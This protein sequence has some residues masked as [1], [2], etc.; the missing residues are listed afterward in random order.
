MRNN[1]GKNIHIKR[2]ENGIKNVHFTDKSDGIF[3]FELSANSSR[4]IV[5]CTHT[6]KM[7]KTRK[8]HWN[9]QCAFS[10]FHFFACC[11]P[12]NEQIHKSLLI[13]RQANRFFFVLT[14]WKEKLIIATI[15]NA[16]HW[17]TE[18]ESEKREEN[19]WRIL[20]YE[21][22]HK[23]LYIY[24]LFVLIKNSRP[25]E[26]TRIWRAKEMDWNARYGP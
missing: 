22:K 4:H 12:F 3:I 21:R 26:Q 19:Y 5:K 9:A 7:N 1:F 23:N 24:R 2:D 15:K 14:Y 25:V 18:I 16:T 17:Q 11:L 6:Q 10:F 20:T 8:Y 13:S